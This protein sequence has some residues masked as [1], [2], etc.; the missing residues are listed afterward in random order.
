MELM[1]TAYLRR[2]EHEAT[3]QAVAI[4][5]LF[6]EVMTRDKKGGKA[7]KPTASASALVEAIGVE[8]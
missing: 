2:K 4:W 7:K 6:G 1:A 8:V 5:K 3:T